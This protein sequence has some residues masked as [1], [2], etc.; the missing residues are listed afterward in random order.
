MRVIE[1][2]PRGLTNR[3]IATALNLS[4]PTVKVHV[5]NAMQKLKVRTR[6]EL[7]A[8]TVREGLA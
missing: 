3:E 8:V 2:L 6:A 1:E 4:E 5:R 7:A